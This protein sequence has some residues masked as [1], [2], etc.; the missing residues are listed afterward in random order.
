MDEQ[1]ASVLEFV[2]AKKYVNA[3]MRILSVEMISERISGRWWNDADLKGDFQP[4]PID[5][6]W[7]W[8]EEEIKY[9]GLNIASE[10]VGVITDDGYVQGA[11]VISSEPVKSILI[12]GEGVLFVEMLFT[13]PRNRSI[14]RKDGQKYFAGVGPELLRWAGMF[15][16]ELGCHG[17]LKL[18]ASPDYLKWYMGL[19]FEK[20][21]VDPMIW[22][23]VE[24]TPVE[25]PL[26][27]V[28]GL[29]IPIKRGIGK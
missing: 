8:D 10:K 25:L 6:D 21:N 29:V 2:P 19:G 26:D 20:L 23:G 17:R 22:E 16:K 9:G 13:A 24:Y 4:V 27:A 28:E 18:D 12:D 11:M 7:K 5:Q 14:L 15:S 1:I 3:V